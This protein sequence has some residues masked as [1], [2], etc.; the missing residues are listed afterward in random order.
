MLAIHCNDVQIYFI[1]KMQENQG[2]QKLAHRTVVQ[3]GT[4][5]SSTFN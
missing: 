5:L 2:N 3:T 1:Q 4:V